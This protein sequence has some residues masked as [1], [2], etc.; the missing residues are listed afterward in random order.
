MYRWF[1]IGDHVVR[2]GDSVGG[3]QTQQPLPAFVPY[4]SRIYRLLRKKV[5][6]ETTWCCQLKFRIDSI[7]GFGILFNFSIQFDFPE[8]VSF[9]FNPTAFIRTSVIDVK[10]NL[11]VKNDVA[12]ASVVLGGWNYDLT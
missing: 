3:V 5:R 8:E 12:R 1:F 2:E 7:K 4:L 9:T 11:S 10:Y 6:P